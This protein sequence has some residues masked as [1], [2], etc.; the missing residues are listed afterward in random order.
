MKNIILL[1]LF[2]FIQNFAFGQDFRKAA[3]AAGPAPKVQIGAYE[4]F[5]LDN[6]LQAIVVENHKLPRVSFQL[7]VESDPVLEKDA[8]GYVSML[9]QMFGKGTAKRTKSQIDEEVDFMGADLSPSSNGFYAQGLKKHTEKLMEIAA[10]VVLRPS[11]PKDEF[12]KAKKQ[13]LSGLASAKD[14]ADVIAG[15]VSR[16]LRNGRSH[17]YGEI[18]TEA[19]VE[20]ITMELVK[21]H[22]EKYFRPNAA[23]MIIVGDITAAEAK[24]LVAKNFSDWKQAP[25]PRNTFSTPQ[26]PAETQVDFVSKI[27]AVQSVV[28]VTFPLE[29]KPGGEDVIKTDVMN[30]I[31]GGGVFSGRLMQNLREKH[32]YTYGARSSLSPDKRV[33]SFSA[34]ASVRNAVTDSS[35]TQFLFE[36]RKIRD[37]KVSETELNT[38]KSYMSGAFAR[39]L[40]EP[41][42][43]ADFALNTARYGLPKDYYVNYLT[44]LSRVTSDDVQA[45]AQKYIHPENAHIVVV[46]NKDQVADKLKVFSKEGKVNFFDNYGN[47]I[48]QK[49]SAAAVAITPDQ[50][51]ENYFKA[52]GGEQKL[53]AVKDMTTTMTTNM[54]GMMLDMTRT[55]KSPDKFLTTVAM[56]GNIVQKQVSNGKKGSTLAMGQTEEIAADELERMKMENRLFKE[57]YYKEL[58][59]KLTVK[60]AEN[61]EGTNAYAL[62]IISPKGTEIVTYFDAKTGLKL[63]E[64]S[65]REARGE[66][67]TIVTDYK[68]YKEINNIKVPHTLVTSGAMPEPMTLELGVTKINSNVEDKIFEPQ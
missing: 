65:T 28:A 16:A 1:F 38:V 11:F 68:N 20:K 45:M 31:L 44:N 52:L 30:G 34:R 27:G 2:I 53:R 22:Y 29:L 19:S 21:A 26:R 58:G 42:T 4:T 3:P 37:E 57:L 60:G 40:E 41:R 51:L 47:P 12:D 39:S 23:Y 56:G 48:E 5:T 35:V 9:G 36:L 43:V 7:F 61:I 24:V 50:V 59:Y 32:A 8:T 54:R 67:K 6:G 18:T 10:D 55:Q 62:Q 25:V 63:R 14:N 46:G 17:P 15:N 13:T 33:G 49:E 64:I 66:A